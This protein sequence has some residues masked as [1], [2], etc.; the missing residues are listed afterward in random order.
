MFLR[1]QLEL[2]TAVEAPIGKAFA[3]LILGKATTTGR[4][5]LRPKGL[6]LPGAVGTSSVRSEAL[7]EYAKLVTDGA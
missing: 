1:R 6:T 4:M 2:S 7:D 5:S 3:L